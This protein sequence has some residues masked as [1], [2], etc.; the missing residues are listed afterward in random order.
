VA[1]PAED[2][3]CLNCNRPVCP[4]CE[5]VREGDAY[6]AACARGLFGADLPEAGEGLEPDEGPD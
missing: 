2:D 3:R 1:D 6:C 4:G 5:Y